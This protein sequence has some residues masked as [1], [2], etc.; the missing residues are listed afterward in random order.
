MSRLFYAFVGFSLTLLLIASGQAESLILPEG[1]ELDLQEQLDLTYQTIPSYDEKEKVIAGW[2]GENLQYIV[3]TGK[4]PSEYVD[5]KIYLPAFVRDL[6]AA[7]GGIEVGKQANYE[8]DSGMMVTVVVLSKPARRDTK[9]VDTIAHFITDGK[10]AFIVSV[11]RVGAASVERIFD[12]TVE[13]LR[14]AK[15][16]SSSAVQKS[17]RSED[18]FVGRWIGEEKLPDGRTF[19]AKIQLKQDLSF[20][21]DV[22]L[23]EQVVLAATGVWARTGNSIH[24][25]Y[26]YSNPE[27]PMAARED[28]DQVISADATTL[29]L[30]SNLSGKERMFKRAD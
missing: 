26:L 7:W 11:T 25:T 22:R 4:L 13:L 29:V 5:A 23:G 15:L 14:T 16:P 6:R 17:E 9:G 27:L 3:T 28:E 8:T 1:L 12:D 19:V 2:D 20:S 10:V 24:W 18:S 21:T 30:K